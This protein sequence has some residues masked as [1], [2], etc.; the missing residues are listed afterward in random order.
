MEMYGTAIAR[1]ATARLLV[2]EGMAAQMLSAREAFA[3]VGPGA[4]VGFHD[5]IDRE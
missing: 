5:E 4:D 2:V 1:I 3:A